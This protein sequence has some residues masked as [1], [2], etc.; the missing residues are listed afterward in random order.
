MKKER[1]LVVAEKEET[2]VPAEHL[3][4]IFKKHNQQQ[5]GNSADEKATTSSEV[6]LERLNAILAL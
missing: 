1:K 3:Q 6:A 5:A 2:R 4:W